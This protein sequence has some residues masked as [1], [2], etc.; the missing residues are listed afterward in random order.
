MKKKSEEKSYFGAVVK[1]SSAQ[2]MRLSNQ[3]ICSGQKRIA[4]YPVV[5]G[6]L[7]GGHDCGA[8]KS[9]VNQNR[10]KYQGHLRAY[11]SAT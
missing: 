5:A 10:I 3:Y 4:Y 11:I 1:G 7:D 9:A 2:I 8:T 6:G